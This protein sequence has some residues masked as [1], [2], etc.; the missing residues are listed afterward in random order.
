MERIKLQLESVK[1]EEKA[2]VGARMQEVKQ[3]LSQLEKRQSNAKKMIRMQTDEVC[4][5]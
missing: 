4:R 3:N 2:D 5:L 1:P